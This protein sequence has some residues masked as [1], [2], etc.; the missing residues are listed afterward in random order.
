MN[1]YVN[2]SRELKSYFSNNFIF[3]LLLPIDMVLMFAGLVV[4]VIVEILGIRLGSFINALAFWAFIIGALLTYANMHRLYLYCG[5]FAY[6]AINLIN[7]IA[8]IFRFKIF[9][10]ETLFATAVSA[11]LG[12]I[13]FKHPASGVSFGKSTDYNN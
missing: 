6:A 8:F 1:T 11:L 2:I 13:T 7:L 12:Y 3:K 4:M 5:L 10:W 9:S